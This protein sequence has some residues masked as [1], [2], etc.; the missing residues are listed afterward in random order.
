MID[1]TLFLAADVPAAIAWLAVMALIYT[2]IVDARTGLVP[3][4][5]LAIAT[6][7]LMA[8]LIDGGAARAISTPLYALLAYGIVWAV[9]EI[10]F[11]LTGRDAL[12]LGDGHWSLV[13]VLAY[14]PLAVAMAWGIGAWLALGWLGA[15]RMAGKPAG[16]VYF[17]PFI[18]LGLIV[19]LV[20]PVLA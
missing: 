2:A 14:G 16:H 1:I 20:M 7:A 5:P 9:N 19:V 10:H 13:A 6:L 3:P 11:K 4:L 12:G 17:V 8:S 15:R 18:L